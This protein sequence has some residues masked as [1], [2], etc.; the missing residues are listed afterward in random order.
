MRSLFLRVLGLALIGTALSLPLFAQNTPA[1]QGTAV[2]VGANVSLALP[3]GWK[4]VESK[5]DAAPEHVA[6]STDANATTMLLTARPG[7]PARRVSLSV[8]RINF[9]TMGPPPLMAGDMGAQTEAEKA[10]CMALG[11]GYT[12]S[13]VKTSRSTSAQGTPMLTV[14]VT[15]KNAAGDE[16][17]F[18]DTVTG[19]MPGS[20]VRLCASWASSDQ[21]SAQDLSAIVR[22]LAMD[23]RRGMPGRP[24]RPGP[25]Q[26]QPVASASPTPEATPVPSPTPDTSAQTAQVVSEYTT[27]LLMVEGSHGVGSGFLCKMDGKTYAITNA[28][29]VC[30]NAGF[31]LTNLKSAQVNIGATGISVGHDIVRLE[32]PDA[33]KSFEIIDSLE[34]NVKIGDPVAVLGN[35]Q[36]AMVVKPVEGKVVGIGPNL[37]EVDAPFVPGNSGSPIFHMPS[38]KVIGVATYLLERKVSKGKNEAVT[39]ETRRFGYRLDSAK[40]WEPVNWQRLYAQAAQVEKIDALSDDFVKLFT[41]SQNNKL[42]ADGFRTPAMQRSVQA[43]TSHLHNRHQINPGERKMLLTQFFGDLRSISR[44][45]IVGFDARGAYD[46]FR[47][48]IDE[49]SRFREEIYGGLTKAIE[50]T[51]Q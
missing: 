7:D 23:D 33:A 28:H 43:F 9:H 1:P 3:A 6:S 42:E 49:Q 38:G 2:K 26:G 36:G 25:P 31:K 13:A 12:P 8:F 45:D 15:A 46:Y 27:A 51:S 4:V 35:A 11:L 17:I 5:Q 18:S 32:V 37:V 30:N 22:S 39:V 34:T 50:R 24:G 10:L 48:A 20:L 21:A 41:D 19:N 16:R 29:V 14:E 47:R 40:E 44:S